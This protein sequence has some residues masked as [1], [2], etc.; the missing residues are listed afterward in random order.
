MIAAVAAIGIVATAVPAT[1]QEST[2]STADGGRHLEERIDLACARVPVATDRVERV[3]ARI[4]GGPDV[5]GSIAWLQSK[6]DEAKAHGR[7]NLA[8]LISG[9]IDIRTERIDVLEARRDW[10]QEAA[11]L[12]DGR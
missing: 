5:V 11:A 10:L 3:L 2:S 9:R 7:D 12:C 1:A 8:D 4:Q 6:A